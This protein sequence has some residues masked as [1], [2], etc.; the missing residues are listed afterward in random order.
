MTSL[1]WYADYSV[2]SAAAIV[3]CS[4][5]V[6]VTSSGHI[7][8]AR[9]NARW[10][11]TIEILSSLRCAQRDFLLPR[12]RLNL[13]LSFLHSLPLPLP[14]FPS[15]R[16]RIR[17]GS[18]DLS[19]TPPRLRRRRSKRQVQSAL[20]FVVVAPNTVD[21]PIMHDTSPQ[22]TLCS[23]R[24]Y[25]RGKV[26]CGN[27]IMFWYGA[28]ESETSSEERERGCQDEQFRTCLIFHQPWTDSM[29]STPQRWR[30]AL[31]VR[32]IANNG[33]ETGCDMGRVT[34]DRRAS[35]TKW[36]VLDCR[37]VDILFLVLFVMGESESRLLC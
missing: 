15:C 30:M 13:P 25:C 26:E 11:S 32:T 20:V 4:Q 18:T 1:R 14:I 8:R 21:I 2:Y 10:T 23:M 31:R 5:H 6:R 3:L 22:L 36:T 27:H 28:K 29:E 35:I 33:L 7:L 37:E 17:E 34:G 12:P 16:M 9:A 19:T 24:F